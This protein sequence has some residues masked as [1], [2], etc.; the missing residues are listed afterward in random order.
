[1]GNLYCFT[2]FIDNKS[3]PCIADSFVC[4]QI[5][6]VILPWVVDNIF[7]TKKL[8]ALFAKFFAYGKFFI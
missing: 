4:Q 5:Y 2:S 6:P 3:K 7:E 8:A 1:M